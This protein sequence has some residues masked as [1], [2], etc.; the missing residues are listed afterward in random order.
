M[1]FGIKT[2]KGKHERI[3]FLFI[4]WMLI[5]GIFCSAS[6]LSD[7]AFYKNKNYH[8]TQIQWKA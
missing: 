3:K 6:P 2:T 4:I 5:I 8:S 7:T 1:K